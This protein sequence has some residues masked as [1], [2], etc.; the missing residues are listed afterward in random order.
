MNYFRRSLAIMGTPIRIE[1]REGTNPFEGRRNKLTPNQ[2][3]KRKRM[4]KFH[5]KG[6]YRNFR[7]FKPKN[8][9]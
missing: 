4:M 3:Y 7:K 1:F 2:M 9:R 8:L 5:K 6:K